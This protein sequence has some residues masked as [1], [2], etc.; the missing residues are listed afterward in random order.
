[1]GYGDRGDVNIDI[2]NQKKDM[3]W[4]SLRHTF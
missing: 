4:R 3:V 1:M 2:I